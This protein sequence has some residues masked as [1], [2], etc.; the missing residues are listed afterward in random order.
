MRKTLMLHNGE[1]TVAHARLYAVHHKA[2]GT[3]ID[4]GLISKHKVT[5]AFCEKLVAVLAGTAGNFANYKY[6][7]CGTGVNAEANTDTA[8]QTPYGGAR[9]TGTQVAGGSA[10]AWTYTS[11][12]TVSFTS[13]LTII[14]HGLFDAAAAGTL[15]DRSRGFSRVV[16]SGDSITFTY[17]L[18]VA[19]EA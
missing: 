10:G 18:T 14:E 9:G 17:V 19:P 8:L 15:M 4:L 12:G 1:L 11:V 6:H 5:N 3:S 16:D 2:D 7:D 13:T